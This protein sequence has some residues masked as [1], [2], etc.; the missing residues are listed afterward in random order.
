MLLL[1]HRGRNYVESSVSKTWKVNDEGPAENDICEV[2]KETEDPETTASA[3]RVFRSPRYTAPE[4]ETRPVA[5]SDRPDPP[6]L[7]RRHRSGSLFMPSS[8]TLPLRSLHHAATKSVLKISP[9]PITTGEF[10][11][12]FLKCIP[13]TGWGDRIGMCKALKAFFAQV[14][15]TSDSRCKLR[16]S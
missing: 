12:H 7:C 4:M 2:L 6:G 5:C 3:S 8:R 10:Y 11:E 1:R 14:F 16:G 15:T 13:P 9:V